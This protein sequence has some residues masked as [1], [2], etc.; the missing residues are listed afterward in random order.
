VYDR[1]YTYLT[2]T[3]KG[4][5]PRQADYWP[6]LKKFDDPF[7]LDPNDRYGH[8]DV[9][10]IRLAEIYLIAAEAELLLGHPAV[11]A[12]YINV[13]RTRAAWPGYEADMQIGADDVD[14]DFILDERAR[15][16]CGEWI[17]WFDLKRT[18]KLLERVHKFNPDIK[19][20]Q[21]YHIVRP[22]PQAELDALLNGDEYGQNEGY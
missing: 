21:E 14:I 3:T 13:I 20:I 18:G 1:D 7:R 17:R 22:I 2:S 5:N 16:L 12:D 6:A 11:A 15:E 10:L 8:L 4:I 9:I 19:A